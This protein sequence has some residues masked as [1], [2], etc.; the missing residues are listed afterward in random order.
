LGFNQEHLY[1]SKP[2]GD[3]APGGKIV[4]ATVGLAD[5]RATII[6]KKYRPR[7]ARAGKTAVG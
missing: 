1:L 7:E 5:D 2:H 3:G 6:A 4:I